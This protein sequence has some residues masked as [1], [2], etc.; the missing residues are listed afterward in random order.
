M[1]LGRPPVYQRISPIRARGFVILSMVILLL[2]W[3]SPVVYPTKVL[4]V[5]LHELSHALTAWL[6]GGQVRAIV[7]DF[8]EGGSCVTVGGNTFLIL[9]A[10]YVGSMFIGG[11]LLIVACRTRLDRFACFCVGALLLIVTEF[12]VKNPF[13]KEVGYLAGAIA[14]C[15]A[16][17]FSE[18]I[19]E[20]ILVHVALTSC[21]YSM[22]DIVGDILI[23]KDS[24]P[25]DAELL[26]RYTGIPTIAWGVLWLLLSSWGT[27]TFL[28]ISLEGLGSKPSGGEVGSVTVAEATA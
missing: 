27:L 8:L 18:L 2:F 12:Y 24:Y 1:L 28:K 13:G 20:A 16:L 26:S 9:S 5:F 11:I 6:S 19:C 25:S 4:V 15:A 3:Q 10:G 7:V 23:W 17:L 21:L 14:M 22:F